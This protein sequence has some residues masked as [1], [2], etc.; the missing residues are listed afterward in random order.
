MA[1]ESKIPAPGSPLAPSL[2]RPPAPADEVAQEI[3]TVVRTILE[4]T[5]I[6]SRVDVE[7]AGAEYYANIRPQLSKGLLIGRKGGT[8][9]AIQYLTRLIVRR[10]YPDV[11]PIM[12]DVGGYRS[13][14]ES[15][16]CK[17]AEAVARI[18]LE[19][20]REMSLDPLTEKERLLVEEHLKSI[21]EVR[22][23]SIPAGSKQ[24]VIIAPK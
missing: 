19:T 24:N 13:R 22:T 5:G 18:V 2:P 1:E 8:L 16:L 10:K 20:K 21:P 17:K 9:K 7:K 12:I 15:F 14:R 11:A 4:L 3:V 6:R 23:Y